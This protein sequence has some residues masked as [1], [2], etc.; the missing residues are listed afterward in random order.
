MW[1]RPIAKAD[2]RDKLWGGEYNSPTCGDGE[3][4]LRDPPKCDAFTL[5]VYQPG[6][7]A[8]YWRAVVAGIHGAWVEVVC[9]LNTELLRE[10]LKNT[11]MLPRGGVRDEIL[12]L[13]DLAR[14]RGAVSCRALL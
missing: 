2:L 7:V 9:Y 1:S 6:I 10:Q 11:V 8:S 5:G 13:T 3:H 12:A 4:S 14:W